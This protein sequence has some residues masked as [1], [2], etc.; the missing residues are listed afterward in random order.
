[1]AARTL[2]IPP[3]TLPTIS[4]SPDDFVQVFQDNRRV[5]VDAVLLS[6]V[7]TDSLTM[8]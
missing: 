2:I 1:M 3:L 4:G 6:I 8:T 7:L 5:A